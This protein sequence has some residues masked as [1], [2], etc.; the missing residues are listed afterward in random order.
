MYATDESSRLESIDD[1]QS[2]KANMIW[3]VNW[4]L[5]KRHANRILGIRDEFSTRLERFGSNSELFV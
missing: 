2:V 4:N 1:I 3:L 5:N